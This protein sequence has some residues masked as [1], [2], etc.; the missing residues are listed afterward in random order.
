MV[1]EFY[2]NVT[3]MNPKCHSFAVTIRNRRVTFSV[4]DI[5]SMYLLPCVPT[6]QHPFTE[7]IR[8]SRSK[9]SWELSNEAFSN[10]V[11]RKPHHL[12]FYYRLLPRIVAS[13]VK[14]SRH[15]SDISATRVDLLYVVGR[16]YSI[17]LANHIWSHIMSYFHH[18]PGTA[19]ILYASLI[20][21]FFLS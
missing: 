10:M 17:N 11:T 4:E 15:L 14:S 19:G 9:V 2:S 16:G 7:D 12:A 13:V 6:P 1:G 20:S 3:S 8:P 21:K 5:A 18:P